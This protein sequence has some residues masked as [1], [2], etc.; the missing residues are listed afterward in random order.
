MNVKSESKGAIRYTHLQILWRGI[1]SGS[2]ISFAVIMA[3][4]GGPLL[5]GAFT[6]FP[7]VISSVMFIT[8]FSQGKKFSSAFMKVMMVSNSINC[9]IY[10]IAVRFLYLNFGLILGTGISF[11]ISLVSGYLIYFFVIKKMD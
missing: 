8:Y 11:I 9:L 4:I 10:A 7:A 5:G 1:L 3:K 2:I 6:S